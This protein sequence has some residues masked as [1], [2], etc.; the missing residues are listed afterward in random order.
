MRAQLNQSLSGLC[1]VPPAGSSS[2]GSV[3]G[4]SP[5]RSSRR[6]SSCGPRTSNG[7]GW[8]GAGHPQHLRV[9]PAALDPTVAPGVGAVG[10]VGGP[11][12][13][14]FGERGL[15]LVAARD[16][17]GVVAVADT[18]LPATGN[19]LTYLLIGGE[20]ISS[21]VPARTDPEQSHGQFTGTRSGP[22]MC[23]ACSVT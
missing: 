21:L 1:A 5:K 20:D 19:D 10:R 17:A 9:V 12:A 22:T 3:C 23:P 4:P 2:S 11:I 15:H 16:R 7:P 13:E 14:H 18:T 6:P 8:A